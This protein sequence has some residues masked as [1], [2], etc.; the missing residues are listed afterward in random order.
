[1]PAETLWTAAS[2]ATLPDDGN[3]YEIID[4]AL[5]VTPAPSWTHQYACGALVQ[6][7]APYAREQLDAVV[8]CAPV[9]IPFDD[10]TVV[11]P[12][13]CV[14]PRRADG[15]LPRSFAEA[16]RLLLAVE[17]LSPATAHRDR[18]V[19]RA[20][21]AREGTTYWMVDL[22]RRVLVADGREV[23]DVLTWAPP[24]G[25]APLTLDVAAY[26]AEVLDD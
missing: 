12:D 24:E 2:L 20:L 22:D 11:Q 26:F 25:R 4:G 5:F 6:R 17:V 19:K 14:A 8:L 16:G 10:R 13:V 9:D 18:T 7:L 3:R 1:M 21:Y 15:R 23:G